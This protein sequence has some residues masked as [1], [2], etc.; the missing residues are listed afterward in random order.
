[1]GNTNDQ[2]I[3]AIPHWTWIARSRR[4]CAWLRH[5]HG[6]DNGVSSSSTPSG[7][8]SPWVPWT[9]TRSYLFRVRPLTN[10]RMNNI[11]PGMNAPTN[12]GPRFE[13]MSAS[14]PGCLSQS[15]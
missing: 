4:T 5:I 10:Q 12:K 8:V 14:E 11:T 13:A 15:R 1:M 6:E 7:P 3:I 2:R 9:P